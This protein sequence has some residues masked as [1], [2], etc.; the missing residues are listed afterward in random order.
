MSQSGFRFVDLFAGIGGLRLAA[1]SIGGRCVFTSEWD[2]YAQKIYEANFDDE[3]PIAGDIQQIDAADIPPHDFLAAG[4]PCQPFSI[5]GVSKANALGRKHGFDHATQGTLFHDVARVIDYH[6]P[7]GFLL[8]NV[9]NLLS[10]IKRVL[11]DDLGYEIHHRVIEARHFLPQ[12]RPR[13]VIVGFREPTAF[14]FDSLILPEKDRVTLRSI[15][16]PEDGTEDAEGHFTVGSRAT[17]NEKYILTENLWKY[18]VNYKEKHSRAGNGFG[19]GLVG[20]DDIARTLSARY[21]KDGSEILINRGEGKT[22]RRLTPRECARLMG[23]PEHFVIPVSD[24]RAYKAF[25]N[26]VAVPVFESV[27]AHLRPHLERLLTPRTNAIAA[28]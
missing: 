24:M 15:L 12:R 9:K 26:S 8:E 13:I 2:S 14:D 11:R 22:P 19:F 27:A 28:E 3:N 7:A 21:Y 16:H 5:A 1:E 17:V 4:F 18:L 23:F 6:R 10:T 25:G 20:P